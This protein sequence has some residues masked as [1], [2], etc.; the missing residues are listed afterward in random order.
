MQKRLQ[1]K[2][3]FF[4]EQEEYQN[5]HLHPVCGIDEAGRGPLAGPLSIALVQF[6]KEAL[7]LIFE[8]KIL[9]DLNDSKKL[10]E[11][12]RDSLFHE[13]SLNAEKIVHQF[14]SN[15]FIDKHGM[16]YSIFY[17]IQ[18]LYKK[19]GLRNSLF[20]IDGNYKFTKYE[21]VENSFRYHSF[22]KGDSRIASI[23]AA[24]IIAKVKRDRFM[25]SIS[26]KYPEYEF[27]KHKGYGTSTH[28]QK[29]QEFGYSKIHRK[30]FI[31]KKF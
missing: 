12:K 10:S 9:V 25:N 27:E 3:S 5:I 30:S 18:K 21:G 13:I 2:Q 16:S 19:S 1:H 24:S 7:N 28:L 15:N 8:R 31:I 22:I 14:I 17:G 29:I 4:F 20:L 23:A 11:K 6:S 26:K